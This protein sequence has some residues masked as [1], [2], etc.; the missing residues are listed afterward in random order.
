[1]TDPPELINK[2]IIDFAEA[3]TRDAIKLNFLNKILDGKIKITF[4][5]NGS[6]PEDYANVIH[7]EQSRVKVYKNFN[8]S[9]DPNGEILTVRVV[10][11]EGPLKISLKL[12]EH[13][14]NSGEKISFFNSAS[15]SIEKDFELTNLTEQ[16][17]FIPNNQSYS[18]KIYTKPEA[19]DSAKFQNETNEIKSRV[20][21]DENIIKY[22]GED[23]EAQDVKNILDD[24]KTKLYDAEN[25]IKSLIEKREKKTMEIEAALR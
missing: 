24:I 20:E 13:F 14:N 5:L 7:S 17:E 22:Y 19:V 3:L 25:K 4:S 12:P 8:L 9:E 16:I 11:I 1:M 6:R 23:N 18:I 2:M 15:K 10:M 21:L